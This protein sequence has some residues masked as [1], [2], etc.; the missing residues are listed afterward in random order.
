[1]ESYGR[2]SVSEFLGDLV[3]Y[4]NLE[5]MDER[6]PGFREVASAVGLD[7]E[8][9]PRKT[10]PECAR[11]IA[12]LLGLARAFDRPGVA[13]DK[14]LFV[15]DTRLND[16]GAFANI[17][18]A[19]GWAGAAFIG[20]EKDEPVCTEVEDENGLTLFLA[21]RWQAMGE[22][23][24]HCR[25]HGLAVDETTAVIVDLDKTCLGARGR[26]DRLIDAARL[27]AVRITVGALLGDSF[28]EAAFQEAYG[29]LNQPEFHRFT[30]D[31]Q[32]YLAYICLILGSG[33]ESQS[34]VE[35][36]VRA[37]DLQDFG[38]FIERVEA[39]SSELPEG[40]RA[41]HAQVL[42]AYRRGDPTPF[43]SFRHNE[44][45]TTTELMGHMPD[46]STAAEL[47][48]GEITITQEVRAQALAWREAGALLF[49]LS[50]K[51]D[52]ASVPRGD[53]AG[54]GALPIHQVETH[55]VGA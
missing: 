28:A 23:D 19:G 47:L 20:S 40:L 30:S 44:Y 9:I 43:K 35:A 32:D 4:R 42:E 53:T 13:L 17:C 26:N 48:A 3:A 33:M 18:R 34:D 1:M 49:G 37:G 50:D 24:A 6:L 31:N 10:Q 38:A 8:S 55:A 14:L 29:E 46:T 52:E 12:H 11:A 15:G 45:R 39:R 5:P 51:P 22:F 36:Q 54:G 27:E 7:P 2:T 41:M 21:N 25:S 16:G